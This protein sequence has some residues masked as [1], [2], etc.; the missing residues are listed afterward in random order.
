MLGS[1][2]TLFIF[3]GFLFTL[4]LSLLYQFLTERKLSLLSLRLPG[5]GADAFTALASI[6]MAVLAVSLLPW[7]W[8]PEMGHSWIADPLAL[9]VVIECAFLL[10]VL[11][12]LL[13]PSPLAAR[14][15]IREAQIGTAARIVIW[16]GL[17][18][19]LWGNIDWQLID[20]PARILAAL[21]VLLALPAAIGV[22]MFRPDP[23]LN[24][25]TTAEGLDE[26]TAKLQHF[27]RIVRSAALI[28]TVAVVLVSSPLALFPANSIVAGIAIALAFILIVLVLNALA[29]RFP[30]YTLP[31]AL[32][33]CIWRALPFAIAA[34]VYSLIF[35]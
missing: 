4:A 34:L 26:A 21:G 17:G 23:S 11:P 25:A 27:A 35:Q 2:I 31:E 22:L 24:L 18:S 6:V 8:H 10:P 29:N 7:P 16:L 32:N 15:I 5:W 30:R 28:I 14:A 20:L 13:A 33:W 12:G 3:P 9:W 1:A 19:I